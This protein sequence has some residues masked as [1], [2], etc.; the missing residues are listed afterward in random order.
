MKYIVDT[1][2]YTNEIVNNYHVTPLMAKVIEHKNLSIQEFHKF[3]N[4]RLVY[5]DFSL[6]SEAEIVLDRIH[7]A[8]ENNEKICIYG[9]YDCDGILATSIMVQCFH[10]LGMSVGYHIPNRFVDGYGLNVARVEQMAAKGYT[11]IITVDNGVKAYE[12]VERANELGVDVIITDHHTFD[13]YEDLPDALSIIHTKLSPDYPYNEI[14]GGFIA[15]KLAAALLGHH[16]KY[17]YTLAA[18]TTVSDMMPL[19]DENRSTVMHGLTFM[20]EEK[21]LPIDL[22][23]GNSRTY[24]A[25]TVGF[26][27]APKIN[28]LGRLPE[29]ANPNLL[30]K[31]F[32]KDTNDEYRVKLA[33]LMTKINAKRQS[34]TN[35]QY[36]M[37][38][39]GLDEDVMFYGS[40][41]LHEGIIGL[42]AGKY[43]RDYNKP[44]FV[45]H[46]DKDTHI[47]RGSCRGVEGFHIYH[48]LE[49]HSDLLEAFGGHAM[50]GG[51]SVSDDHYEEFKEALVKEIEGKT[52]ETILSVIPLS[53]EDLTIQAIESLDLLEPFGQ[54]NE[55]PTFI[56]EKIKIQSKRQMSAGR[57]LR[58]EFAGRHTHFSGL[59]FNHGDLYDKLSEGQEVTI[60]GTLSINH[61]RNTTSIDFLIKDMLI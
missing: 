12:A 23:M 28:S 50:A 4:K 53:F 33:E 57:H 25:S 15:Y 7:E 51:F 29:L 58:L 54:D 19:L 60:V 38:L 59:Y 55:A 49:S 10:E 13:E 45:M 47:Y 2:T 52:F 6:F 5:H 20:E 61:F 22:L 40:S 37:A 27:I 24:N 16:D 9:D 18:I 35:S 8:I 3:I 1:L 14:C 31:Y 41:D 43:T 26:T 39:K 32:L 42:I 17:L 56:F 34:L 21:F 46:Y 44:A 11:L 30:V 36:K 48:F